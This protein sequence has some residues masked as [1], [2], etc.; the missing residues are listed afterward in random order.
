MSVPTVSDNDLKNKM[1]WVPLKY[2]GPARARTEKILEISD[3]LGPE[4]RKNS[5]SQTGPGPKKNWTGGPLI[6]D[7]LH[8][9][10]NYLIL[11]SLILWL[12]SGGVSPNKVGCVINAVD[13]YSLNC[14][15]QTNGFMIIFYQ[16][17]WIQR[18]P[19]QFSQ[20]IRSA[21]T[22]FILDG[23]TSKDLMPQTISC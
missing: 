10:K 1:A 18:V 5:N 4:P 17:Y 22:S 7:R 19:S 16:F 12:I 13:Y 8:S 23:C 14:N 9:T 21:K 15:K 20:F 11:I 6:P 2:Q 3:Q